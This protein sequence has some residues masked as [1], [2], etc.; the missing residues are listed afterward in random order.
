MQRT[1][2]ISHST[3]DK[4]IAERVLSY[5]ESQGHRCWIAPRDIAPG[6]DWAE[7][8]IDSIDSACGMILIVT[9]DSRESRQIRREVERAVGKGVTIYPILI[10]KVAL[11]KWMQYY[12]TA[13]QWQTTNSRQIPPEILSRIVKSIN[14]EPDTTPLRPARKEKRFQKRMPFVATGMFILLIVLFAYYALSKN[15]AI[16]VKEIFSGVSV[17][18]KDSL[19]VVNGNS[20][21]Y[22]TPNDAIFFFDRCNAGI[23]SVSSLIEHNPNYRVSLPMDASSEL[24]GAFSFYFVSN[25]IHS[26]HYLIGEY[27]LDESDRAVSSSQ[28]SV[29]VIHICVNLNSYD[30][31]LSINSETKILQRMNEDEIRSALVDYFYAIGIR[32]I[33][34][35]S[36]AYIISNHDIVTSGEVA[37]VWAMLAELGVCDITY[38]F[39]PPNLLADTQDTSQGFEIP[40]HPLLLDL[41]VEAIFYWAE[42]EPSLLP[43]VISIDHPNFLSEGISMALLFGD[44]R[45]E[46]VVAILAERQMTCER[47]DIQKLGYSSSAIGQELFAV[48]VDSIL[49]DV[50]ELSVYRPWLRISVVDS[51]VCLTSSNNEYFE[52]DYSTDRILTGITSALDSLVIK[53]H[54]IFFSLSSSETSDRWDSTAQLFQE[55]QDALSQYSENTFC[56]YLEAG[57]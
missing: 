24:L 10:G 51:L 1:L 19:I 9:K 27:C 25:N 36:K 12:V 44:I 14:R 37:T 52:R 7:A 48:S 32:G 3:S 34:I 23:V 41:S 15:K 39:I 46:E 40:T 6:A 28:E 20:Q 55:C 30:T 26:V 53:P 21:H 49:F 56:Y 5:L 33:E 50:S 29:E 13:H 43:E 54:S 45:N 22:S 47:A 18:L 8:I 42:Y 38:L 35:A 31:I 17:T 11:S 4:D 16:S 57:R 2:F